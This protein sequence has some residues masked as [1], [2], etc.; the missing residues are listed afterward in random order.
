MVLAFSAQTTG[1]KKVEKSCLTH[2]RAYVM[3]GH[4]KREI[5]NGEARPMTAREGSSMT[6][7]YYTVQFLN[8]ASGSWEHSRFF[9]TVRAA[10][11]WARW[12]KTLP[13]VGDVKVAKGGHGGEP[14]AV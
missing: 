10:M 12:L 11:S 3:M 13:N 5:D 7:H 2:K 6:A 1:Q 4:M 8:N 14:V 9:S